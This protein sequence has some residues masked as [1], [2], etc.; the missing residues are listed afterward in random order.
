MIDVRGTVIMMITG[1]QY[2]E[3]MQRR[4]EEP[5]PE[6]EPGCRAASPEKGVCHVNLL[7]SSTYIE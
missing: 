4:I 1:P 7:P 3:F 6:F 5:A 2:P